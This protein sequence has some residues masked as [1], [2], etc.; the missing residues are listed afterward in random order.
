MRTEIAS[1][2]CSVRQPEIQGV[3]EKSVPEPNLAAR[4]AD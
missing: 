3:R 4:A 2:N 1:E